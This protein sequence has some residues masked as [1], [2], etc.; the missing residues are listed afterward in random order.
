MRVRMELDPG[1]PTPPCPAAPLGKA[2][3]GKAKAAKL[4]SLQRAKGLMQKVACQG[5]KGQEGHR[6][7]SSV[8]CS[9]IMQTCLKPV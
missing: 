3:A 8:A 1:S 5:A 6:L 7:P 4:P 9:S 2:A